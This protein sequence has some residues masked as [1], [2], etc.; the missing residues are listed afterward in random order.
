MKKLIP[1]MTL[2][3]GVSGALAQG[4][5]D[6]RNNQTDFPTAGQ[7]R[8]VYNL[9]GTTPL[10]GT[11]FQARLLYGTDAA[12]L[13]P[14]TYATPSRFNNITTGSTRAGTWIG[15][16]RTLTGF[17]PGSTVMLQVQLWDAGAGAT[18]R[19]YDEALAA[20]LAHGESLVFAYT[21]PPT[22]TLNPQPY[23]MDNLRSFQIVPEPSVIGLGLVGIGALF[24]LR[25]RKA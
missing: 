4:L 23:Y 20:G 1:L 15:G 9:D 21:V 7:D 18:G 2:L 22:G 10:V 5:V 11:N 19:T 25:R 6:F 17:T 13:Q 3:V 8:R 16:N 14:A 24:M 12:S